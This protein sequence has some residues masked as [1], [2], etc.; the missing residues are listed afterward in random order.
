[1][2]VRSGFVQTE[3]P[4]KWGNFFSFCFTILTANDC[5]PSQNN[6]TP[7][8]S[9]SI[10][11][12][13]SDAQ[14]SYSG[15]NREKLI[16][17]SNGVKT[18]ETTLRTREMTGPQGPTA[19]SRTGMASLPV[20]CPRPVGRRLGVGSHQVLPATGFYSKPVCLSLFQTRIISSHFWTH[21]KEN[22]GVR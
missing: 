16:F 21:W 18:W 5:V 1:M 3:G 4:S 8:L 12:T 20:S 7:C 14:Y 10:A 6:W 2:K 19:F 22:E 13:L 9:R 17:F 15:G 11:E